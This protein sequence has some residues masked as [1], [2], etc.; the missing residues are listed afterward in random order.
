ME[1]RQ[2]EFFLAIAEA[3]SFTGAARVLTIAQPSL[4]H[5]MRTLES[6]L[7]TT[8]FERHGRG[9]RLTPAGEA[10]VGPARRAV[11]SFAEAAGAVRGAADE[12]FAR[13][14]IVTATPWAVEP[15]VP[16]VAAYRRVRPRV[17]LEV[18]DPSSRAVVLEQ[19]RAGEVDL[20]LVDGVAPGGT[21]ASLP[22]V[23]HELV[24]VLPPGLHSAPVP[25]WADLVALGLV[26][27]PR[28]TALRD[29]LDERLAEVAGDAEPAVVTAHV[30]SLVPLV[31]AGAGVAVLPSGMAADAARQ[32]ARTAPLDPPVRVAVSLVWRAD[33]VSEA[34]FDFVATARSLV[35]S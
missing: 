17:R 15:L 21:V 14:R 8:L 1:R 2:L 25:T 3:G 27:T 23:E 28:G 19:V 26:A 33:D 29:L 32:G 5:S 24:A 22:L 9:V 6:E 11:R 34:A 10:L 4:S 35:Q 7:G 16:L 12:G 31:L 13:L 18:T 20:G 30:A